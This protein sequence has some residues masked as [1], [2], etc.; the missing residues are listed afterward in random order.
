MQEIA[1]KVNKIERSYI[2]DIALL[3]VMY[4]LKPSQVTDY[5][6]RFKLGCLRQT[7]GQTTILLAKPTTLALPRGLSKAIRSQ[8]GNQLAPFYG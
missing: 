8:N 4:N 3:F 2:T 1:M 6:A 7:R 5:E